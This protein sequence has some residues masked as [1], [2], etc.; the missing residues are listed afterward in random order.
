MPQPFHLFTPLLMLVF[1]ANLAAAQTPATPYEPKVGQAGK[2][3]VWVPTPQELVETMLDMAE[4]GPDD[5]VIDLGSGDGRNVIAAARRGARALGVEFNPDMVELSRR[6]AAD[7][8]VG[9][10]AIFEQ[11]DMFA[12]DISSATVLALFLLPA[13]MQRLAPKFLNLAPGSR[14]VSNTF[15][16]EGWDPDKTESLSGNCESWCSAL[17]WIVPAKVSGTWQTPQGD[18]ELKQDFQIVSGGLASDGRVTPLVLG[19]MRGDVL[20]FRAADADYTARVTGDAMQ[21]T[22]TVNGRQENWRATRT[23]IE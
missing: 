21:G 14:I 20:S 13:N 4:V 12:R 5:F 10:T 15:G 22:R 3:V 16:I 6:R 18:L 2:D 7:A 1:G 19:R 8:G 9:E 23:K 17:L 11:G